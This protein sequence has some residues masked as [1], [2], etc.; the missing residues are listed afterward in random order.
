[1]LILAGSGGVEDPFQLGQESPPVSQSPSAANVMPSPDNQTGTEASLPFPISTWP[2]AE[3]LLARALAL[4]KQQRQLYRTGRFSNKSDLVKALENIQKAQALEELILECEVPCEE[5]I[6][7]TGDPAT[8]SVHFVHLADAIRTVALIQ[9]YRTFPDLITTR[10]GSDSSTSVSNVMASLVISV[11]D[12]LRGIA[13]SSGIRCMLP[14]LLVMVASELLFETLPNANSQGLDFTDWT[15]S[16]QDVS[17]SKARSFVLDRL[18]CFERCLPAQPVTN[19][20]RLV[21]EI[22]AR[23]DRGEDVFWMDVMVETKLGAIF[24]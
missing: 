8:P 14:I 19:A 6:Q 3:N 20:I 7:E 21:R 22:W 10:L 23:L 13:P 1:M 16:K 12:L 17:I 9:I 4:T 2:P 24:C 11:V 15:I 18:C 5:E